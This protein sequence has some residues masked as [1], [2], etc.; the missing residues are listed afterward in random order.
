MNTNKIF[1]KLSE[2]ALNPIYTYTF[3]SPVMTTLHCN[4]IY[5][6][7][8]PASLHACM[9]VLSHVQLFATLWTV[10]HWAPLS[11]EFSR[12]E[13]WSG[14]PFLTPGDLPGPRDGSCVS[15]VLCIGR[16]FFTTVS[17]RKS[18]LACK[19]LPFIFIAP[20]PRAV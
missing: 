20:V 18:L 14:L 19:I 15:C 16:R 5:G 9:C 17:P 11:M 12:Q 4:H 8:L 1:K 3:F 6:I 13:Y 2:L 10:A 7:I